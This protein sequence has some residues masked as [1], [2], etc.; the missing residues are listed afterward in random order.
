MPAV[1]SRLVAINKIEKTALVVLFTSNH[2]DELLQESVKQWVEDLIVKDLP[3]FSRLA[4][5]Q[6]KRQLQNYILSTHICKKLG[7]KLREVTISM[8]SQYILQ[9]IAVLM[10]LIISFYHRLNWIRNF[11]RRLLISF[12]PMF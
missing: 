11:C 10:K 5:S 4:Y 8:V 3:A 1:L 12:C 6:I 2:A 9:I 7:K